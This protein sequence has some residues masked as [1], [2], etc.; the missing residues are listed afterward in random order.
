MR[1]EVSAPA[2]I[3]VIAV[4]VIVAITV[5]W[6]MINRQLEPAPINPADAPTAAQTTVTPSGKTLGTAAAHPALSA[7]PAGR[8]GS[9]TLDRKR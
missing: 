9:Q 2:M 8:A 5:G 6:Y 7:R 4:V 1:K 3:A